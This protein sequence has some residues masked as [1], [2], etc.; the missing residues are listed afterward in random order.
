MYKSIHNNMNDIAISC[1]GFNY[2]HRKDS[3]IAIL[4]RD[5]SGNVEVCGYFNGEASAER[6]FETMGKI[7]EDRQV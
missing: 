1:V 3:K 7:L 4:V 6:F 5:K 2:G